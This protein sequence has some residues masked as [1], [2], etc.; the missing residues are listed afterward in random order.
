MADQCIVCLENLDVQPPVVPAL[1]LEEDNNLDPASLLPTTTNDTSSSA[2]LPLETEPTSLGHQ[3][4]KL[5]SQAQEDASTAATLAV[6]HVDEDSKVAE[7]EVCGHMLHDTCLRAWTIKANSCPICRQAFHAVN[8]YDKVG[9][10]SQT[11]CKLLVLEMI[12]ES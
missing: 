2:G 6:E 11:L 3:A 1:P 7:I 8:V 9:G 4:A 12:C 5:H 10:T